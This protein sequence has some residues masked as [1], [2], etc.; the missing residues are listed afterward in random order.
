MKNINRLLETSFRSDLFGYQ[1]ASRGM[2]KIENIN[3]R[4][5]VRNGGATPSAFWDEP[6]PGM[7][8]ILCLAHHVDVCDALTLQVTVDGKRTSLHP[9]RNHW[10]PAYMETLYR[11]EI[12]PAYYP[13]S[14]TLCVRDRKT[15]TRDDVFVSHLT[16]TNQKRERST[17]E[18][19]FSMPF[20]E[21]ENGIY[22]VNAQTMP[23]ALKTRYPMKGFAALTTDRGSRCVT[24]EIP[25]LS[26]VSLRVAMAYDPKDERTAIE[27]AENI[28]TISDPFSENEKTFNR[29]FADH[30]PMLECEN[31][32]ILKIYYYRWYVVYR[33]I[34]EP[35]KWI[36]GHSIKGECMY[37]SPYGGWFGTVIGLPIALQVSD[38]G[39]MRDRSVVKNQLTNWSLGTVAFQQYI[40]FTPL[41][42]WRC[43]KLCR[44]KEWLA[45]VYEGFADFCRRQIKNGTPPL[46][47]GSW[48]TGAEYQPSFYQ[49]TETPWDF[50][51]DEEGAKEG[52]SKKAIHR[53]DAV[54]FLIL[55]LRGCIRMASELGKTADTEAFSKAEK[56]LTDFMMTHMWD[57]E[58]KFF[59]SYDPEA[60]KRCDKAAC[61][62]GFVP[63]IDAVAGEE[64]FSAL[65]TLW[66]AD[67]FFSEYGATTAARTCPMFWYDNCIA[68]PTASS[69][70][71][72][73][74]YGCSWN[75]TVWPFANS[76]IAMG[77]GDA[78]KSDTHLQE[79]WLAFFKAHT[80]LHF[81][82]GD[83]GTPV[84]CEHYRS[85]DGA[86]F[87]QY[88]EYFH[89]S[90]IDLF[91]RYFAGISF[92]GDTPTFKPFSKKPFALY[93]VKLANH[94]YDFIHTA[95]GQ[96]EIYKH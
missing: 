3:R 2:K 19:V 25:P 46:T 12:D 17:I 52:F 41:A 96:N 50:R 93:G 66:D 81:A 45:S 70:K 59:Y 91:M 35:S 54:M 74:E 5:E 72:P 68:G 34:H 87:S 14:G 40:Q 30:V 1:M 51:H 28:L 31:A 94:I 73:H 57:P 61:Y 8:G 4:P 71:E 44:D 60:K 11:S 80:E 21:K 83:R 79:R 27:K 77:L 92:D 29:W 55:S 88:V 90:W 65:E 33:S 26:S 82:Y 20:P 76:L 78:A 16:F 63:F 48:A 95:D 49:Y 42:A 58:T 10:T 43:Y 6:Q 69:V 13:N 89:S 38:A 36:D 15:I 22:E 85:D 37:E 75:G 62:D 47:V 39:W 9:T 84:I 53:V 24:L 7:Q 86:C 32:D 23:R 18:L 56:D 67:W 64:Y